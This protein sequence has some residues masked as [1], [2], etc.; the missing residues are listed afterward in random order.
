MPITV[1]KHLCII[2]H[3]SGAEHQR[4]DCRVRRQNRVGLGAPARLTRH[5]TAD[6]HTVS[7]SK[8]SKEH[9]KSCF[10]RGALEVMMW[11]A[12]L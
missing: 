2:T 1:S 4:I 11:I 7:I 3:S 8:D 6:F 10:K 5:I 12:H 9:S